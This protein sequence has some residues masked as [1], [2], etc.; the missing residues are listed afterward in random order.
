MKGSSIAILL[1]QILLGATFIG[2]ALLK[3]SDAE[4]FA[5]SVASFKVVPIGAINYIAIVLP[6]FELLCGVLIFAPSMRS[7]AALGMTL[8]A[9]LFTVLMV[10]GL[11][12]GIHFDC[13]CFGKWDPIA[14]SPTLAI[15]RDLFICGLAFALNRCFRLRPLQAQQV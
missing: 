15:L 12:R 5:T 14:G 11:L 1:G 9:L 3:M 4:S 13:G 6:P 8:L 10:Q 7:S 2:A